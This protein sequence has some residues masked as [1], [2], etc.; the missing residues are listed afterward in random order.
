LKK[1]QFNQ[2]QQREV[3][4]AFRSCRSKII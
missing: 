2:E 4:A 3:A 1:V